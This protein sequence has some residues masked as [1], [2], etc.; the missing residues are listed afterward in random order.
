[1]AATRPLEIRDGQIEVPTLP[2]LGVELDRE[3]PGAAHEL[4]RAHGLWARDDAAAHLVP[5]WSFDPKK[6][7]L[8]R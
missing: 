1:M 8:A 4:Y 7:C 5:G 3:R 6:P 2:G